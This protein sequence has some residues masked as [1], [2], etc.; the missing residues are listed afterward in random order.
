[1]VDTSLAVLLGSLVT[2][3][4]AW[5]TTWFNNRT[6]LRR[7]QGI[8]REALAIRN[9]ERAERDRERWR[10][11]KVD[12]YRRAYIF[13]ENMLK[14]LNQ[15]VVEINRAHDPELDFEGWY[16]L[17]D[18]HEDSASANIQLFAADQVTEAYD[19][20]VEGLVAVYLTLHDLKATVG[21]TS[22]GS[23]L[24]L[25]QALAAIQ[26]AQDQVTHFITIAKDDLKAYRA[27]P[28]GVVIP[29]GA[30]TRP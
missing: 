28:T 21:D 16:E 29:E 14:R 3:T 8:R 22:K 19:V 15:L 23:E 11:E 9:E 26:R 27:D 10:E 17:Y 6:A 13:L 1:M 24:D 18:Q 2:G 5:G 30:A 12:A 20:A 7:E 25:A 4:V